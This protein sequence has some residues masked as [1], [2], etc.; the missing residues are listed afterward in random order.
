MEYQQSSGRMPVDQ[1]ARERLW[2][3]MQQGMLR[4]FRFRRDVSVGDDRI[5]VPFVSLSRR[6]V[7][8]TDLAG[9]DVHL[10]FDAGRV[11][12]LRRLGYKV[13]RF[14]DQDILDH[15]DMVVDQLCRECAARSQYLEEDGAAPEPSGVRAR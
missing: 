14:W 13:I 4:W 9:P 1:A 15:P 7:V 2:D 8:E 11:A 5:S 10:K 12:K 6:L 3:L